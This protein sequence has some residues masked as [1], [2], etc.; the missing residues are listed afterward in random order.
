ML[1]D[2]TCT[3][4]VAGCSLARGVCVCVNAITIENSNKSRAAMFAAEYREA[5][6]KKTREVTCVRVRIVERLLD[7][8]LLLDCD[9]ALHHGI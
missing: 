7:F 3:L 1:R 4:G 2:L 8:L 5:H 9:V 6:E